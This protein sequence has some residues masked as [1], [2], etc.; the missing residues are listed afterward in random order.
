MQNKIKE[1][2]LANPKLV[3]MTETSK[4][5]VFVLKYKRN[6]FYDNLWNDVLEECRGTLVDSAFN[7]ISRP[8]TKIYNHTENGTDIPLTENVTAFKKINGFM[9]AITVYQGELLISTTGSIDSDFAK[10]AT[11][12]INEL[13]DLA[14]NHIKEKLAPSE[15]HPGMTMIVEICDP[16]DPHIV[17]EE[18]GVY[19]LGVRKNSWTASQNLIVTTGMSAK[20]YYTMAEMYNMEA[21]QMIN[22]KFADIVELAKTCKHEGFV[23]YGLV[24]KTNLKIKSPYYKVKKFLARKNPEKLLKLL[25]NPYLLKQTVEEEFYALVDYLALNKVAYSALTE[26]ERLEYIREYF[27]AF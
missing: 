9:A 18:S 7:V 3:T 22:C 27:N 23:V 26:Q 5:G 6:V 19:F 10:L 21:C 15:D 24:G 2:V 11:K 17:P 14:L 13:G 8:F 4:A 20:D 1:F 16:S 12:R 25:D